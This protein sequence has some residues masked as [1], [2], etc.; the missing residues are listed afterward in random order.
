MRLLASLL[1]GLLLGWLISPLS[2]AEAGPRWIS[3]GGANTEIIYALGEGQRLVATD[4]TSYYPPEANETPKVGYM[5]ALATEG[6]LSMTPDVVI[7]AEG[8]GPPRV[9]KQ[10]E[11]SGLTLHRTGEVDSI[12]S[13]YENIHVIGQI[14]DREEAA[15]ALIAELQVEETELQT[16]RQAQ[17][18]EPSVLFIMQ[19]GAGAPLVGGQETSADKILRLSGAR[20]AAQGFTGYK[21]LTPEAL[22][23]ASP[24]F[25]LT[26]DQGLDQMGGLDAL[27]ALPGVNLVPAGKQK[28]VSSMDTLL[29][30]GFGPRTL[31]AALELNERWQGAAD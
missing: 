5:R 20:N 25:I 6:I 24:D 8:S 10:L 31:E 16:K 3:I 14:L 12:A 17:N 19:H 13:L 4:T 28:Q 30:L 11:D 22:I 7:L 18:Q 2:W 9:I 26:T 27:L 23:A 1:G 21:P 15:T 29:L